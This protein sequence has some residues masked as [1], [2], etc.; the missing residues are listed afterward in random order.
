MKLKVLYELSTGGIAMSPAG[1][2]ILGKKHPKNSEIFKKDP[3]RW[4]LPNHNA[5]AQAVSF[6]KIK[7]KKSR[8]LTEK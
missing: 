6:M 1:Y 5:A 8:Q 2:T 3:D 4:Y 7:P